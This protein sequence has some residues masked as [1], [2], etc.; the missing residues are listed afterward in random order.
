MKS[1]TGKEQHEI[2]SFKDISGKGYELWRSFLE[3]N[4]GTFGPTSLFTQ[5]WR[6]RLNKCAAAFL[7]YCAE[8][9]VGS[10]R[11]VPVVLTSLSKANADDKPVSWL[12]RSNGAPA[13]II[14]RPHIVES[15]PTHTVSRCIT[16]I[17]LHEI[18]HI[19]EHWAKLEPPGQLDQ[20]LPSAEPHHEAEAWWFGQ[21]VV[22]AA[23]GA[24]ACQHRKDG[25]YDQAWPHS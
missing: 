3:L 1:P 19:V 9:I 24:L 21:A 14:D 4:N 12:C 23:V 13:V 2:A 20:P 7:Q 10:D 8:E 15:L 11:K 25:G 22:G 6:L 16:R 5:D 17:I 18:G